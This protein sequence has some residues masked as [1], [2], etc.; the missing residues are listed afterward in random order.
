MPTEVLP[1]LC[2]QDY[3]FYKLLNQ[4]AMSSRAPQSSAHWSAATGAHGVRRRKQTH[5]G[6]DWKAQG[7]ALLHMSVGV[8]C[9]GVQIPALTLTSCPRPSWSLHRGDCQI[10]S[11]LRDYQLIHKNEPWPQWQRSRMFI[12]AINFLSRKKQTNDLNC[13]YIMEG[14]A[15]TKRNE[16]SRNAMVCSWVKKLQ[17]WQSMSPLMCKR[18]PAVNNARLWGISVGGLRR[19]YFYFI[20]LYTLAFL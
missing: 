8:R 11:I 13:I 12:A 7:E 3:G 4:T 15:V 1:A 19:I 14:Y 10:N 9:I 5:T 17:N 6:E 16:V 18:K 2:F 20:L